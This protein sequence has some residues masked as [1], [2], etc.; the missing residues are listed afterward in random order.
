MVFPGQDCASAALL[1]AYMAAGG[2]NNS[3]FVGYCKKIFS[4]RRSLAATSSPRPR[5]GS[6]LYSIFYTVALPQ[7]WDDKCAVV[8]REAQVA[9]CTASDENTGVVDSL[10][11]YNSTHV[12]FGL[13]QLELN[14]SLC[15]V[16][17]KSFTA[18]RRRQNC[19]CEQHLRTPFY[20]GRRS[21]RTRLCVILHRQP[22]LAPFHWASGLSVPRCLVQPTSLRSA[23]GRG[24]L[25][26]LALI[27]T[28]WTPGAGGNFR[29]L[30]SCSA[31]Y[32]PFGSG[33]AHCETCR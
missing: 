17:P 28:S 27:S 25:C 14:T 31:S 2:A 13:E 3:A 32:P 18:H 24:R 15:T 12:W 30:C 8:V 9:A 10:E 29:P 6:A 21:G 22:V 7:G 23:P 19:L 20:P 26:T 4:P 16:S 33:E 5:G 11:V 1:L